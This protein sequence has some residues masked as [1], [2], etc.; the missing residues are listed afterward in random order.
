MGSKKNDSSADKD[1]ICAQAALLGDMLAKSKEYRHYQEAK[2]KLQG[3]Q[4]KA[5]LF[6]LLRQQQMGL[7]LAQV[8]GLV[9]DEKEDD[10]EQ[11][12]DSF[13]LEPVVCDFLYAE[14]RL[15][16]LISQVQQ[17]CGDK[18]DLWNEEEAVDRRQ[19]RE[20]N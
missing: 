19:Y 6:S 2:H 9:S 8:L 18:L 1:T 13:C 5:Y 17:I 16:R 12:Y 10:F 4:E 14:G 20:L 7:R 15:G 3:D 11:I